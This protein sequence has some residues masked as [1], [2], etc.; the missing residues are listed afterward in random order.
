MATSHG[1]AVDGQ[2]TLETE[3]LETEVL[4]IANVQLLIFPR[5]LC[6]FFGGIIIY[7]INANEVLERCGCGNSD[8]DDK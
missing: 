3:V 2:G 8:I 6:F 7:L 5:E 1:P 4:V